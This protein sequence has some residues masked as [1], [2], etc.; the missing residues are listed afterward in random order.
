MAVAAPFLVEV[1]GV[2]GSG[3]STLARLLADEA[4]DARLA[5]FIQTRDPR[6]IA[7]ALRTVPRLVPILTRN[8]IAPPRLSWPD[9]KLLAYVTGW[10]RVVGREYRQGI[11]LFDQGP[12]YALVRLRAQARGVMGSAAF[13]R[14]WDGS[15]ERWSRELSLV[16]YLDAD[17]A[18]LLQRIGGR[19]QAH[20]TKGQP[21]DTARDFLAR[22]RALFEEVLGRLD[23][24]G[25][26]EILRLDTGAST[27]DRIAAELAPLLADR[28]G[29]RAVASEDRR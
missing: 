15:L 11:T 4:E 6:H 19:A 2:A 7:P 29:R 17:D 5:G 13:A 22:Y 27:P 26:P 12:L 1:T 25:G 28:R 9:V 16:V 18:V 10:H 23:R 24:P 20:T 21:V 14:W 3:K 8:V